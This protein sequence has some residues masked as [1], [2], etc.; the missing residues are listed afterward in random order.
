MIGRICRFYGNYN[1]FI[2]LQMTPNQIHGMYWES[3]R[4]EAR[5]RKRNLIDLV[6][7]KAKS[8]SFKEHYEQLSQQADPPDSEIDGKL[9]KEDMKNFANFI[10]E[11]GRK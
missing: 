4:Q 5:E 7:S 11:L 1:H 9:D 3:Y 6:M 2:C 8:E 10:K